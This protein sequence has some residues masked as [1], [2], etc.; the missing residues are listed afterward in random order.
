[1]T[2]STRTVAFSFLIFVLAGSIVFGQSSQRGRRLRGEFRD[3]RFPDRLQEGDQ[4]P[5]FTLRSLDGKRTA[6]LSDYRGKKPVALVFGSY[7]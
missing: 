1:M 3:R 7:T 5:D 6:T 4:A 2:P